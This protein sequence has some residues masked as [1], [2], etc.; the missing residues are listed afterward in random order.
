M[1]GSSQRRR[2]SHGGSASGGPLASTVGEQVYDPMRF[3]E[4]PQVDYETLITARVAGTHDGIR[5][6]PGCYWRKRHQ[7]AE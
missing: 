2:G 5:L 3:R 7:N 4:V 1:K 6:A